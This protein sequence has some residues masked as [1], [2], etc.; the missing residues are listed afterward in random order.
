MGNALKS[1]ARLDDA[2]IAFRQGIVLA[3]NLVA[4]SGGGPQGRLHRA[5]NHNGL[6]HTLWAKQQPQEA[7]AECRAALK[8][9]QSLAA[10]YPA[11]PDHWLLVTGC[12]AQ[13]SGFLRKAQR[14]QE[15]AETDWQAHSRLN[16]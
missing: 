2:E 10:D 9:F 12:C 13:L 7:E 5:H 14:P 3:E 16:A 1:S 11:N 8:L 15:A 4:T 6:G